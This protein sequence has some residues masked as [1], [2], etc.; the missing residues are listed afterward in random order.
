MRII[1]HIAKLHVYS[2]MSEKCARVCLVY[3][4]IRLAVNVD[5]FT[6]IKNIERMCV[7]FY[8]AR[9]LFFPTAHFQK[10]IRS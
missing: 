10:N 1:V 7:C 2:A 8:M 6:K 4:R 5:L 3:P 9:E